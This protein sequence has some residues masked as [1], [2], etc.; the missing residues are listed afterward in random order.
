M[1]RP[2]KWFSAS[3]EPFQLSDKSANLGFY[4]RP[5]GVLHNKFNTDNSEILDAQERRGALSRAN[6][7]RDAG[8]MPG[9]Y[10]RD[11]LQAIHQHLFQDTYQWAGRMRDTS[12]S[13]D[14]VGYD[15]VNISKNGNS[16]ID[17][18]RVNQGLNVALKPLKDATARQ[19][20]KTLDG[21]VERAGSALG[22]L[23]Y[24][25][26]FREGNGRT[27]RAFLEGVG[28][29]HGHN[30]DFRV[31]TRARM[32][33]A[34]IAT[35]ND[36]KADDM[37]HLLRDATDPA[38]QRALMTAISDL[39]QNGTNVKIDPNAFPVR[40]AKPFEQI[41]GELLAR[42]RNTASISTGKGIVVI[43]SRDLPPE[44][45]NAP[46]GSSKQRFD[47]I[48]SRDVSRSFDNDRS[49]ATEP[50]QGKQHDNERDGRPDSYAARPEAR[51]NDTEN[52][53]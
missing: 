8:A 14:G 5:S 44:A 31:I 29:D 18:S 39:R 52:E 40:T 6:Q 25:H 15:K 16:F 19:A 20:L 10:D 36:P 11:H 2:L 9:D 24:V 28:A 7:L 32:T 17:Q 48:A 13:I 37:K 22:E 3:V 43:D 38:R 33:E 30:V 42:D 49:Q 35:S 34:S 1:K 41:N 26:P 23:N 47:I 12:F 4:Q 51:R 45:R 46:V 27:Q 53:R 21:F 50:R